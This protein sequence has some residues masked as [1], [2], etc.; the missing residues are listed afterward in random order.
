MRQSYVFFTCTVGGHIYNGLNGKYGS[1]IE[2]PRHGCSF[3]AATGC[4]LSQ[5]NNRMILKGVMYRSKSSFDVKVMDIE[6]LIAI[7]KCVKAHL[8]EG[9]A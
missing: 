8:Y 6:T 1:D 5:G 3:Q 2:L 7:D 4:N 9:F